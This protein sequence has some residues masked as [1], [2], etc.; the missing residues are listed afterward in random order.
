V[1][2]LLKLYPRVWRRRY[3]AEV[4]EMLA[5]RRFS[6]AVAVDLVAGAIDVRLHPSATLAAATAATHEEETTM[7]ARLAGLTCTAV[8]G[9]K[10]TPADQ[11]KAG[12][13][14]IGM[15]IALSLIWMVAHVRIG[16]NPYVDSLSV[17]TY[18]LPIVFSTRYTYLKDRPASVQ[19]V[20]IGGITLIIVA[21]MLAAGWVTT[22]I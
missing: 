22:Q 5:G 15:T 11:W 4:A 13:T 10:L 17:L 9:V 2:W 19:A 14:A 20:F 1:T 3:G 18:M 6:L 16:D 7:S 21:I 8:P 12:G